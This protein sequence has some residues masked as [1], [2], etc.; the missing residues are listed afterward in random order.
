[1]AWYH[2]LQKSKFSDFGQLKTMDYNP[3]FDFR[4]PKKVLR[5]ACQLNAQEKINRMAL[6]SA[7]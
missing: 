3:W 6:V 7:V 4:S 2:F 1:M 5:K